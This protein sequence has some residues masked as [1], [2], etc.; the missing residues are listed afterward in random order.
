MICGMCFISRFIVPVNFLTYQH[1]ID[2]ACSNNFI[3]FRFIDDDDCIV[4]LLSFIR[5]ILERLINKVQELLFENLQNLKSTAFMLFVNV[6][7]VRYM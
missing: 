5:S 1:L 4:F 3:L 2:Y 6:G 7:Y